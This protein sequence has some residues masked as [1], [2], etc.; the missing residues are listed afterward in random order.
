M[1]D[2]P[3]DAGRP[4]DMTSL[5][6]DDLDV[7]ELEDKLLE[8]AAGGTFEEESALCWDFSCGSNSG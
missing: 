6:A 2:K 1:S 3:E 7:T 4:E 5:N 8:H